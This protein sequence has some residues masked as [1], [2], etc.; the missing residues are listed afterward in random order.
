MTAHAEPTQPCPRCG[1]PTTVVPNPVG[2]LTGRP[3][4][5][6]C[7]AESTGSW[8]GCTWETTEADAEVTR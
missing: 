8:D 3:W 7:T 6:H 4:L 1:K 2:F 5:R